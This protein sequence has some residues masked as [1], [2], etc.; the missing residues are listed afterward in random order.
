MTADV[1]IRKLPKWAQRHIQL[2]EMRL[3]EREEELKRLGTIQHEQVPPDAPIVAPAF[4]AHAVVFARG[5]SVDFRLLS[6]DTIRI[7]HVRNEHG[8]VN[9]DRIVVRCI[10]GG[11]RIEPRV[12]NTVEIGVGEL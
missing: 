4:G 12:A 8:R 11:L 3:R 10:R 6:G 5:D 7:Q 2:L 1:E 9:A